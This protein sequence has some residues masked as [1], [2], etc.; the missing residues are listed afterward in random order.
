MPAAIAQ[1]VEIVNPLATFCLAQEGCMFKGREGF[2][3]GDVGFRATV[4]S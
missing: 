3:T 2:R 4:E 1:F